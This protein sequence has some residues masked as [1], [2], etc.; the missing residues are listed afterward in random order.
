MKEVLTAPAEFYSTRLLDAAGRAYIVCC[1]TP[2]KR[3]G[4]ECDERCGWRCGK[5][6]NLMDLLN[7]INL[8]IL[9]RLEPLQGH[10]GGFI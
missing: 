9:E 8:L 3:G 1:A 2:M 4:V 5:M 6:V 10:H 7:L